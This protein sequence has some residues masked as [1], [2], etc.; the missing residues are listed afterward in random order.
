MVLKE[1][2]SI[3][4]A[5]DSSKKCPGCG[6]RNF[7]GANKCKRCKSD[8]SAPLKLTKNEKRIGAAPAEPDRSRSSLAWIFAVLVVVSLGVVFFFMRQAPQETPEPVTEAVVAPPSVAPVA[9]EPAQSEAEQNSQSEEVAKQIVT[10]LKS[11][12]DATESGMDFKEYQQKLNSLRSD[13]KN[14]LPSFDRHT[15]GDETFRKE[16]ASALR[17]YTAAENW[18]KTT[19][20]DNTVFTE[21]D[22]KERTQVN[23]ESARSHLENAEKSVGR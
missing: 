22:R 13:L 6:L 19:I 3:N 10:N 7:A 16:V 15:P 14:A 4:N 23:F 21:T 18:W 1:T 11:F 9:E 12:Q 17:D 2:A 20:R 5:S 8:L